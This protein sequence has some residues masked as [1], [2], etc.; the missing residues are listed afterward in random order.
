MDYC[1]YSPNRCVTTWCIVFYTCFLAVSEG[2]TAT[3]YDLTRY[4]EYKDNLT[5]LYTNQTIRIVWSA[6]STPSTIIPTGVTFGTSY[7]YHAP[8]ILMA[9]D[10][11]WNLSGPLFKSMDFQ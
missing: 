11:F 4:P 9:L 2:K 7:E 8:A 1:S 6:N 5:S 10:A 3:V